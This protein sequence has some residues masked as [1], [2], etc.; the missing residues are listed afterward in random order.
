MKKP[1][2]KKIANVFGFKVFIV[3]GEYIR[4]NINEEFT[5]FGQHYRFKFI[6][7]NE[8]WIDKENGKEIEAKY[9]IDHLLVENRLMKEGKSYDEAIER[10][11]RTEKMERVKDDL[12]NKKNKEIKTKKDKINKAHL[13]ILFKNKRLKIWLVD[14]AFVRETFFIDFTEGGH[15]YVYDFVPKDEVWIDDDLNIEERKYV[16]LHEIHERNLM[17]KGWNYNKAHNSSSKIEYYC[18]KHPKETS[19]KI[20]EELIMFKR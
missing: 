6:P 13:K 7:K 17:A 1:Y 11:D 8:F 10:A 5:N 9:Y 3:D 15:D 16:I 4:T 12:M 14:G 20:N 19:K 2:I 18:R